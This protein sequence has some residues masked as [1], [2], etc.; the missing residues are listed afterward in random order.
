VTP[1]TSGENDL[2]DGP[3]LGGYMDDHGAGGSL[4]ISGRR[5]GPRWGPAGE[6]QN[7]VYFYT[8][9]PNLLLSLHPD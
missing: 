2:F 7:R 4:T 6:D 8:I 1:Y 3:Y 5:A 9:F